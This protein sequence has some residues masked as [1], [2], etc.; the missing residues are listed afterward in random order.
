[1]R[2]KTCF[3]VCCRDFLKGYL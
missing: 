1:M 3:K 2:L